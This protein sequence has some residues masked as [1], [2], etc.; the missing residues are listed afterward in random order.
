MSE[1]TRCPII[2]TSN[3]HPTVHELTTLRVFAGDIG[4]YSGSSA[5]VRQTIR[6]QRQGSKQPAGAMRG[7][8][9]TKGGVGVNLLIIIITK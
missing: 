3:Q 4:Q 5:D 7:V 8:E 1:N 2:I 6:R 9:N